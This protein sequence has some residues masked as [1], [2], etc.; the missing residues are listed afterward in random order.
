MSL[1]VFVFSY[2]YLFIFIFYFFHDTLC[3]PLI[4]YK[5]MFSNVL[6]NAT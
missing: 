1:L 4:F 5:K 3:L 2:C 6:G